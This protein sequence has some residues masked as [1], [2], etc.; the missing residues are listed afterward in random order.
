M[1]NASNIHAQEIE[2]AD[3][4]LSGTNIP[5]GNFQDPYI[6]PQYPSGTSTSIPNDKEFWGDLFAKTLGVDNIYSLISLAMVLLFLSYIVRIV[7]G[8]KKLI[9]ALTKENERLKGTLDRKDTEI[10]KKQNEIDDKNNIITSKMRDMFDSFEKIRNAKVMN[11][12]FDALCNKVSYLV[13]KEEEREQKR[14]N[15]GEN[16]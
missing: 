16:V 6:P 9:S 10:E 13:D 15:R 3:Q 4:N 2:G 7:W 11:G 1:V 5:N 14:Q 12:Q 8:D